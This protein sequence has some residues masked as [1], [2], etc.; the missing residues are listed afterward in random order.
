MI[1]WAKLA[2]RTLEMARDAARSADDA[3]LVNVIPAIGV[4]PSSPNPSWV[5]SD[6]NLTVS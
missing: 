3:E 5:V 6:P 2:W 4:M 1:Y